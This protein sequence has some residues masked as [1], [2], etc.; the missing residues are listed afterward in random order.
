M[1]ENLPEDADVA[2]FDIGRISYIWNRNLVDLGGLVDPSY[3]PYLI[4]NEIPRYLEEHH[5]EYVVL[6][7][8]A[9]DG[10]GFTRDKAL[11]MTKL[12][13]F[14]SPYAPWILGFRYTIHAM[15]CQ[16]LYQLHFTTDTEKQPFAS[17]KV[18]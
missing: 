16:E 14:C 12:S 3:V 5:V 13:E 11:K 18:N 10:F 9:A 17:N 2:A 6:P 7:S 8:K 15:E 4:S 1:L